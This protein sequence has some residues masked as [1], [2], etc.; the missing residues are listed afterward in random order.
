[1]AHI[2]KRT[3]NKLTLRRNVSPVL[4]HTGR[5]SGRT[6]HTPLDAIPVE[7]GYIFFVIYGRRSDWVRNVL[8]AGRAQVQIE[9]ETI[10]LAF[11]RLIPKEEA[12]PLLPRGTSEPPGFLKVSE[13][14]RMDVVSAR[15]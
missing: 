4:I 3:F 13:Y 5:S 15:A 1:M 7:G 10:D 2:N 9:G 12:G 11:P 8:A 6:Y 14:L